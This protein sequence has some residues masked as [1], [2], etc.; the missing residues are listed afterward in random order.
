MFFFEPV[1]IV[2]VKDNKQIVLMS[3]IQDF[4]V[5]RELVRMQHFYGLLTIKQGCERNKTIENNLSTFSMGRVY[6]F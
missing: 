1:F 4:R 6:Q 2:A 3:F 5:S